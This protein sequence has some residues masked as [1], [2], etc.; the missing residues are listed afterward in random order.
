MLR[1]RVSI[2]GGSVGAGVST[3]YWLGSDDPTQA[4]AVQTALNAFWTAMKPLTTSGVT[5]SLPAELEWLDVS[6]G[7]IKGTFPVTAASMTGTGAGTGLPLQTQGLVR[8]RTGT[9]LTSQTTPVRH[10]ELRGRT[11]I[12]RPLV[13]NNN[14]GYATSAYQT[15]VNAAANTLIGASAAGLCIYS[16]THSVAADVTSALCW[17]KFA[18]LRSRRD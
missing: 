17:D 6:D 16:K 2:T 4:T 10:R 7:H 9:Y 14:D 11:Y 18:V 5:F 3:M 8:W 15:A 1:S 13:S 12:P